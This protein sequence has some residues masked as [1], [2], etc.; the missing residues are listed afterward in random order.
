MKRFA[1]LLFALLSAFL[2][3]PSA[4]AMTIYDPQTAFSGSNPSGVWSYGLLNTSNSSFTAFDTYE[5]TSVAGAA[6]TGGASGVN[7]WLNSDTA[8]YPFPG[9]TNNTTSSPVTIFS[10]QLI[11]ADSLILHPPNN[12][13]QT[14]LRFTAPTNMTVNIA[15]AF[16]GAD[17]SGT[18]S[19]VYVYVNGS[20]VFNSSI[21]GS[22]PDGGPPAGGGLV[23]YSGGPIALLAGQTVEFTVSYGSND[24]YYNDATSLV[25]SI[26]A[27]PEASSLVLC[28]LGGVGLFLAARRRRKA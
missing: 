15:A 2:H 4:R 5:S 16:S 9:I 6:P 7:A 14:D 18:T 13:E 26:T 3:A 28:S 12:P 10:T 24:V 22:L 1:V 23:S 25:A 20:S 21:T 8:P 17:T 27:V 19:D 11:P